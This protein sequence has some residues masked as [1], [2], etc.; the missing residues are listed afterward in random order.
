[1]QRHTMTEIVN[2]IRN[3]ALEW[4]VQTLQGRGMGMEGRGL[5]G[6]YVTTTLALSSAV[7]SHYQE[8][9]HF[10]HKFNEVLKI[11]KC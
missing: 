9:R 6:F 5:D 2:N 3:A 4:S 7:Y 1:M 10:K 8:H 11:A